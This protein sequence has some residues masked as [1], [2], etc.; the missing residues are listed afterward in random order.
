MTNTL[1]REAFETDYNGEF[2][3][4]VE[5]SVLLV[6]PGAEA[7]GLASWLFDVEATDDAQVFTIVVRRQAVM[8]ALNI[9]QVEDGC[10]QEWIQSTIRGAE[11][12]GLEAGIPSD[13]VAKAIYEETQSIRRLDAE[14]AAN[15]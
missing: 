10:T 13:V 11:G 1:V 14:E 15:S 5:D 3:V 2:G 7:F 8:A 6:K 12:F 9:E 4:R